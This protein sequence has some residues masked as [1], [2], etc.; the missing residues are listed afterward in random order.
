MRRSFEVW[1]HGLRVASVALAVGVLGWILPAEVQATPEPQPGEAGVVVEE[2]GEGSALEK[3]DLLLGDIL[4][5]WERLPSPPANVGPPRAPQGDDTQAAQG[6]LVSPFDWQWL[7][8]EQ[9]PQGRV[10]LLGQRQGEATVF[11]SRTGEMAGG[12]APP[13][14]E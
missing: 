8:I 9:A 13:D 6:E 11:E 2:V 3:A 5:S 7:V 10:K 4:L 12:C 14:A 1:R